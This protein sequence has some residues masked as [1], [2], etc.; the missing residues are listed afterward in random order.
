VS[1]PNQSS[2]EAKGLP[3]TGIIPRPPFQLRSLPIRY[4]WEVTR[5]H[6]YYQ[7]WWK[8]ARAHHR[9]EPVTHPAESL[10]RQAAIAILPVIGVTGEPPDPANEFAQLEADKL[11]PAW[12]SGAVHPI[13][14]RGMAAAVMAGLPKDTLAFLGMTFLEAACDDKEDE[15]PCRYQ[16]MLALVTSDKPG[17]ETYPDEPFVSINPAASARQISEAV[18]ALLKQ[19]K[20]ER[21][22]T[23]RRDRA[24]KYPDY[25]RVWDLR[26]GWTGATYDRT[27]E[28]KLKEIAHQFRLD[29]STVNNHYR[30]AFELIVGYPYSPELW[31]RTF[32]SLKLVEL[33]LQ[34]PPRVSHRRPL[35][36]PTR[37]PVPETVLTK[38]DE[39]NRGD[40][41]VSS[42]A[43]TG[44]DQ[45]VTEMIADI[46][47][48]FKQ[49]ITDEEVAERLGLSREAIPA[50]AYLRERGEEFLEGLR[51]HREQE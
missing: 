31:Y 34:G 13:T 39:V 27:A 51:G 41:P 2:T 23:D 20:K 25:L 10:L 38:G 33:A 37:R 17:L 11:A 47:A 18:S 5:R 22:L 7:I 48:L 14:L 32:A 21:D 46:H 29:V 45:D 26:E 44:G 3:P 36:S 16:A 30:S 8:T 1:S 9:N 43:A 4:R 42:A 15:L 35:K 49:G 40:G 50:I 12:L 19:W 6:P 28:R 24:D